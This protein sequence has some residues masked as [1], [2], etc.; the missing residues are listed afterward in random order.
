MKV[1]DQLHCPVTIL[2]ESHPVLEPVCKRWGRRKSLVSARN[3]TVVHHIAAILTELA[4]LPSLERSSV[5]KKYVEVELHTTTT[6]LKFHIAQ[7]ALTP[8]F[9]TTPSYLA[10]NFFL[11]G[12]IRD[13]IFSFPV[14][15]YILSIECRIAWCNVRHEWNSIRSELFRRYGEASQVDSEWRSYC[16]Q[17]LV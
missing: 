2:P 9:D 17:W 10:G 8:S 16:G 4:W 14:S 7:E 12:R 5:I 6:T 1:S 13:Q 15:I 3:R 11:S